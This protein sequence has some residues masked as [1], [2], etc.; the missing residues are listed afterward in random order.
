MAIEKPVSGLVLRNPYC[1]ILITFPKD[2]R[3]VS[4]RELREKTLPTS[5]IQEEEYKAG[6]LSSWKKNPQNIFGYNSRLWPVTVHTKLGRC[7]RPEP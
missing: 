4:T 1:F 5:T 3:D 2:H 6:R 7:G